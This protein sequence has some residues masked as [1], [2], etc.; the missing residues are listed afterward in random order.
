[1]VRCR[2]IEVMG[3]HFPRVKHLSNQP[4]SKEVVCRDLV[5]TDSPEL[6]HFLIKWILF[7]VYLH[8]NSKWSAT[9][10]LLLHSDLSWN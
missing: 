10:F 5:T 9:G 1:M 6:E 7:A 2:N 8:L 4:A 3:E